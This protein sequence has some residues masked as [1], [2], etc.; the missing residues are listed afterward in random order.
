MVKMIRNKAMVPD[1]IILELPALDDPG[2]DN[3]IKIIK[4]IYNSFDISEDAMRSKLRA[5]IKK[6]GAY[7]SRHYLTISLRKHITNDI[8]RIPI[9]R[10]RSR[11]RHK[12]R[13]VW[14]C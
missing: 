10:T 11:P 13:T 3:S 12:A 5:K 4:E 1:G 7:E 14:L 9:D 2:I 8:I 6:P